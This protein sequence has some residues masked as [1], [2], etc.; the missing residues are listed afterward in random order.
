LNPD[1]FLSKIAKQPLAPVYLF[2]GQEGY[3]RRLCKEALLERALPGEA[4]AGGLTQIDLE[5]TTLAA[6]LDDARSLSLFASDRV[7]WVASAELAL[8]RRLTAAENEETG[9]SAES[10]LAAYLKAPT[11]GTTLVFE[12]S[13]YDFAGD[14]RPKLERVE[15]FYAGAPAIVEFR[16]FT[17]ESSRFLAQTLVR[18]FS[19]KLGGAELA[20]LLETTAGDA[21]RLESEIEKLSLF[22][23]SGRAVTAADLA[24]LVPH[25]AQTT[26]FNL[27]NALGRR[28]RPNALD[29][30]YMASRLRQRFA[31]QSL[32]GPIAEQKQPL[33]LRELD[34]LARNF[35]AGL[36]V[37]G[38]HLRGG[39]MEAGEGRAVRLLDRNLDRGEHPPRQ[40]PRRCRSAGRRSHPRMS[41]R[42]S[43]A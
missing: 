35:G 41:G 27:V 18:K 16:H 23:G 39:G 10:E 4:R 36:A 6:V 42:R 20:T 15:K 21:N 7:I 28:D 24:A 38:R 3:Q 34:V 2:L 19:L 5:N 11:P 43:T 17:P 14:D 31:K 8:P 26:I 22:V 30:V 12:A 9:T 32:G 13:R 1:Q 37:G 33:W 40:F 29:L 25:A